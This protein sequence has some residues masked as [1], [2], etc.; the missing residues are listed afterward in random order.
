MEGDSACYW[1]GKFKNKNVIAS[2]S[3]Q[4]DDWQ[5]LLPQKKFRMMDKVSM[6]LQREMSFSKITSNA[7]K[8]IKEIRDDNTYILIKMPTK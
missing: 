2:K 5:S 7:F 1:K 3:G 6:I 8:S 4:P